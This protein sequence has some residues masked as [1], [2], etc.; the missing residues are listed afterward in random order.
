MGCF[1]S[2]GDPVAWLEVPSGQD[3][4][5]SYSGPCCCQRWVGDWCRDSTLHHCHGGWAW[6]WT[7]SRCTCGDPSP[8]ACS[9]NNWCGSKTAHFEPDLS[10]PFGADRTHC[11]LFYDAWM[12]CQEKW[13]THARTSGSETSWWRL[14]LGRAFGKTASPTRYPRWWKPRWRSTTWG[15]YV[16]SFLL[17]RSQLRR[18]CYLCGAPTSISCNWFTCVLDCLRYKKHNQ[19]ASHRETLAWSAEQWLLHADGPQIATTGHARCPTD[20]TSG[21]PAW[22]WLCSSTSCTWRIGIPTHW[23][24]AGALCR[25][26]G[27]ENKCIRTTL[28]GRDSAHLPANAVTM[29]RMDQWKQDLW[30]HRCTAYTRWLCEN[31]LLAAGHTSGRLTAHSNTGLWPDPCHVQWGISVQNS[32]HGSFGWWWCTFAA[33]TTGTHGCDAIKWPLLDIGCDLCLCRWIT[34]PSMPAT[35]TMESCQT[36]VTTRDTDLC[37]VAIDWASPLAACSAGCHFDGKQ[38]AVS[39]PTTVCHATAQP[40]ASTRK[41]ISWWPTRLSSAYGCWPTTQSMDCRLYHNQEPGQDYLAST[42]IVP[43]CWRWSERWTGLHCTDTSSLT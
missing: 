21:H 9:Y 10:I 16:G 14:P 1:G 33:C 12:H 23:Q 39:W 32:W 41:C 7:L 43:T 34:T 24:G 17:F 5:E 18:P 27:Y 8:H 31:R 20:P 4:M 26:T 22:C 13:K 2:L 6:C 42:W 40:T 36:K 30:S 29:R 38:T 3:P 11:A 15:D 28:L 35:Q 37:Y 25:A 19:W